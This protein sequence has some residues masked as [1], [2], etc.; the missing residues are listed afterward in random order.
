LKR[1]DVVTVAAGSGFGSKPRPALVVQDDRLDGLGNVIL[2]LFT[3]TLT[4]A[5]RT[6]PRVHPDPRNGLRTAS[7]LMADILI[8][9]PRDRVGGVIGHLSAADMARV[10]T[11]LLTILGF[12]R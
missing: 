4:D 2:A 10:E 5:P 7:D 9:V 3:T 11:A 1:G 6:R 8:T 12:A